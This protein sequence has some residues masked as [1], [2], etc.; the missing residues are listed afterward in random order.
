M[1]IKVLLFLTCVALV[2]ATCKKTV[3]TGDIKGTVKDA[4][5]QAVLVNVKVEQVGKN[6]A[7][8]TND[9][10][11]YALTGLEPGNI[12][13][14]FTK[15]NYDPKTESAIMVEAD[16]TT[17]FN[18]ELTPFGSVI[19]VQPLQFDFGA[20]DTELSLEISNSGKADLTWDI[21]SSKSWLVVPVKSG[22]VQPGKK[23]F[24]AIQVVR[25]GSLAYGK[26]SGKLSV[27]NNSG[28]AVDVDVV[29]EYKAPNQAPAAL[30]TIAPE[31]GTLATTFVFDASKTTDD[32]D[33]T[34]KLE[35]AWQFETG[36]TFTAW[37][38][39]K[40]ASYKYAT[41]G[42]KTVTLKARDTETKEGVKTL[43]LTVAANQPPN[44]V[45][46]VLPATGKLSTEFQFDASA[47]TDDLDNIAQLKFSWQFEDG[48][49]FTSPSN[50]TTTTHKYTTAGAKTVT[51]KAEDTRGATKTVT[52]TLT[53][54]ANQAPVPQFT[55]PAT[56]GVNQQLTTDASA[57][58]D[59]NDAIANLQVAWNFGEGF[60][61]YTYNKTAT[62]TYTTAGQKTV[63]LKVKDA[64]GLENT[65]A[66]TINVVANQTP[67]ATFTINPATGNTNT[68]FALDATGSTD[69]EDG[70][71]GLQ[72]RWDKGD[73]NEFSIWTTTKTTTAKYTTAGTKTITLEVKDKDG[74]VGTISKALTVSDA[75]P[76]Y[77][78]PTAPTAGQEF[79]P[80]QNMTITWTTTETAA[81]VMIELYNSAGF[82]TMVAA[83]TPNDGT[84]NWTVPKGLT[85][86]TDYYLK[87]TCNGISGHSPAFTILHEP[88]V[89]SITQPAT[90]VFWQKGTAAQIKWTANFTSPVKIELYLGSS[91]TATIAA[92]APNTGT[93]E[94][95][96]PAGLANGEYYSLKITCQCTEATVA[97]T[98]YFSIGD[99]PALPFE[100]VLINGGTFTMG[101][102]TTEL[103]RN[104]DETQHSVTLSSF[105][106]G[107]YEVTQKLWY[108]IMG[109]TPSYFANCDDCPVEQV[110]W[111][112]IQIFLTALN[113]K[114]PGYNFR[115]PTEAEWEYAARA[116]TSTPF[117]T[118][119]CLSTSQANYDGNYPYQTC[120]KGIYLG[121][122]TAVG[123]YAPNAYGLY[124]MYGNVWEWCSDWYGTYNTGA[125][126]N[127][128]GA[129]SGSDRVLRGG[130]WLNNAQYC[131][132]AYRRD[133]TPSNR[134]YY[135]GF[136][137]VRAF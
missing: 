133:F 69:P 89:L 59:D 48:E 47:T 96:V 16:K 53:I 12:S 29:M 1:K 11:E 62:H 18:I 13:L 121:K 21:I 43:T 45:F 111:D 15:D 66:K 61:A 100:L 122:T 3:Q 41:D 119:N 83:A 58:T 73:G 136:R 106:M 129:A 19:A 2:C 27:N 71:T 32:Y 7:V 67:V 56:V 87:I 127:P 124:D 5:S 52:K 91:L 68:S 128:T 76:Q 8:Q 126:T 102:P 118:G 31:N 74:A 65:L 86:N 20:T 64:Q 137:L 33:A 88:Y 51:L 132:S 112:D 6:Q 95:Q 125:Q 81:T 75:P 10:G 90:G 120:S 22:T 36:G 116:G 26:L 85:P 77:V 30:F 123:S 39:D 38:K 107:K 78:T 14:K 105:Y 34:D 135:Y 109:T 50:Q 108:D 37:S 70:A 60:S 115:L 98:G 103:D 17:T 131:R 63:T 25:S 93:Y 42:T 130:S 44:A 101:S 80:A 40:T 82:L 54:A 79:D 24:V 97:Q 134:N 35:F 57:S 46:T 104:T 49:A 94:Y 114:Y 4:K 55:L 72:Y 92:S 110:S 23:V 99:K 113:N 9:K 117:N 84:H 28:A